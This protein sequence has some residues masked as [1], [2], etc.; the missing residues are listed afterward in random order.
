MGAS[1]SFHIKA[2]VRVVKSRIWMSSRF[3]TQEGEFFFK[4][5]MMS[6]KTL[7]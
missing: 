5:H 1:Y 4:A 3:N 6:K 2:G 7:I